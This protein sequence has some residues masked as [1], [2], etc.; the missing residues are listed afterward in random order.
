MSRTQSLIGS[1]LF[2]LLAPGSVAGLAPWIIT[3]WRW[4]AGG[5][6][7]L[8]TAAGGLLI[9]AGLAILLESFL[10][11]ALQGGG[12]PAPPAPTRKLVVAGAY[13]FVRNPMYV[14]VLAI[15]IGQAFLF[16]S[17]ELVLYGAIVWLACHLFVTEFEEPRLRRDFPRDY[18]LYSRNVRRWLPR[19]RPWRGES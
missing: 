12:T 8:A 15:I 1:A 6:P 18:A 14:A 7:L 9:L 19:I 4:P 2:L 17:G 16:S 5:T 3:R 13:R 10:R 11:F